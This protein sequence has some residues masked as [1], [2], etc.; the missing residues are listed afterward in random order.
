MINNTE[1]KN[2]ISKEK[3]NSYF[4][5]FF[6]AYNQLLDYNQMY[7]NIFL[8]L[9]RT[10]QYS[11]YVIYKL[12]LFPIILI[13]LMFA[14]FVEEPYSLISSIIFTIALIL[15][16]LVDRI[17]FKKFHYSISYYRKK[18]KKL[19]NFQTQLIL[20]LNN[21][22]LKEKIGEKEFMNYRVKCST[23]QDKVQYYCSI[24]K[25]YG[26]Y[27]NKFG[28]I[29]FLI[30]FSFNLIFDFMKDPFFV[31]NLTLS[32]FFMY[33]SIILQTFPLYYTNLKIRYIKEYPDLELFEPVISKIILMI[34]YSLLILEFPKKK[35]ILGKITEI[36]SKLKEDKVLE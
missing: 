5:I 9:K 18:R 14:A 30:G 15:F 19:F 36:E 12:I 31:V 29:A 7:L 20:I 25:S 13:T 33:I 23:I 1:P 16:Y 24:F 11:R 28:F 35:E 21:N 6:N 3:L 34:N 26:D 2:L 27:L 22:I 32:N 4:I 17:C 8:S 10:E